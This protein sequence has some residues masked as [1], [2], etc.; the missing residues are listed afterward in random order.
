MCP[1]LDLHFWSYAQWS[2]EYGGTYIVNQERT[3][4]QKKI[5]VCTV[6]MAYRIGHDYPK[7]KQEI[8]SRSPTNVKVTGLSIKLWVRKEL[9][10]QRGQ[11]G[12]AT[13][14]AIH[15]LPET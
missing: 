14:V 15:F 10:H 7:S 13:W 9:C 5:S 12:A 4:Y 1:G 3:K 6:S 8:D 2:T 11:K